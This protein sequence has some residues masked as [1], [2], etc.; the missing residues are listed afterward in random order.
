MVLT[1]L[2]KCLLPLYTAS[3]LQYRVIGDRS[4]GDVTKSHAPTKSARIYLRN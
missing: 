1:F 2:C 4:T 3:A